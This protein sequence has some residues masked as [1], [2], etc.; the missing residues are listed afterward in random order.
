M[1]ISFSKMYDLASNWMHF[2]ASVGPEWFQGRP[3]PPSSSRRRSGRPGDPS[4]TA[5]PPSTCSTP[6]FRGSLIPCDL[7]VQFLRLGVQLAAE[8]KKRAVDPDRCCLISWNSI[9]FLIIKKHKFTSIKDGLPPHH[10]LQFPLLFGSWSPRS[11]CYLLA[12]DGN[13]LS[14]AIRHGGR[15]PQVAPESSKWGPCILRAWT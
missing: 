2:Q 14:G 3:A 4:Q 9:F 11:R 12:D 1:S 15:E 13:V 5:G 7:Q 6:T 8:R 10:P